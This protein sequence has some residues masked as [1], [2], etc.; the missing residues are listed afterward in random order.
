MNIK[1]LLVFFLIIFFISFKIPQAQPLPIATTYTQGIYDISLYNGK[2]ITAK[3]ITPDNRLTISIINSNGEQ[4][5]FLRFINPNEIVKLGP[6]QE[7]DT[8]A[9]VGSGVISFSPFQ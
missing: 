4:K 9:I 2:Y 1:R 7:G 5:V 6:I 8:V 3:L